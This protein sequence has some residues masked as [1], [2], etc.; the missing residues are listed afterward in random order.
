MKLMI[1][2]GVSLAWQT[3]KSEGNRWTRAVDGLPIL[4]SRLMLASTARRT[5]GSSLFAMGP[6]APLSLLAALRA[7][8]LARKPGESVCD[9]S[10]I[11]QP[12][13][14]CRS[15]VK[16]VCAGLEEAWPLHVV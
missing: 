14:T 16:V 1:L 11:R 15:P 6:V 2:P 4:A 13:A 9:R 3:G 10:V 8:Y 7:G 5:S 12:A